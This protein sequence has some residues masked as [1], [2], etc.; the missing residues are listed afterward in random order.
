MAGRLGR[1]CCRRRYRDGVASFVIGDEESLQLIEKRLAHIVDG[2]QVLLIIRMDCYPEK[3]VIALGLAAL[4]LLRLDDSDNTNVD[5]ATHMRRCIHEDQNVQ[6]VAVFAKRGGNEA[7]VE[8]KHH[9]FGQQ[10]AR[11]F[12]PQAFL[13][14][15][16]SP[17]WLRHCFCPFSLKSSQSASD[18]GAV[19][20]AWSS[21]VEV[22]CGQH[23]ARLRCG[24]S[25]SYDPGRANSFY[26]LQKPA[27]ELRRLGG[28]RHHSRT[29]ECRRHSSRIAR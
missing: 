14:T 12:S 4:S 15:T 23:R 3:P 22:G 25:C 21:G 13:T 18:F 17:L 19:T 24:G 16:R 27:R 10:R 28:D 29:V 20:A 9:P 2:F 8:G 11:Y 26:G 5:E 6:G 1:R 7:E